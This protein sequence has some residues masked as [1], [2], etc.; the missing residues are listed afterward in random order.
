MLDVSK[1]E[2]D[3]SGVALVVAAVAVFAFAGWVVLRPTV[4][5]ESGPSQ[6]QPDTDDRP[7]VLAILGDSYLEGT[8]AVSEDRS[9]AMQ[10]NTALGTLVANRSAGGTGYVSDGPFNR[11]PYRQR[12]DELL[13]A[14]ADIY[15]IEGGLNDYATIY[16]RGVSDLGDLRVAARKVFAGVRKGDPDAEVV[17]VGPFWPTGEPVDGILAIRDVIEAEADAA[18]V[19]FID[20]LAEEWLTPQNTDRLIGPDGTH[21]NQAGHDYL[22]DRL[23]ASVR[24]ALRA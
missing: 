13:A 9:M 18:G 22:A 5:A 10:L 1:R 2:L 23:V 16:E 15:L 12:I 4:P 8:G 3:L 7:P 17:V 21:P 20:P 24:S 11:L 19:P 6:L 14:D